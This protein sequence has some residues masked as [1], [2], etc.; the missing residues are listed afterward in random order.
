[1]SIEEVERIMDETQD[2]IEYQQVRRWLSIANSIIHY[3]MVLL[4]RPNLHIVYYS[5]VS[6]ITYL[7][8]DTH[9]CPDSGM[10]VLRSRCFIC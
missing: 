5:N 4:L 7:P 6:S 2:A 10:C 9:E 1:M 8:T 3:H